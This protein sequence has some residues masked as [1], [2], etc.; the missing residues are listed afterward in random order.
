MHVEHT[1]ILPQMSFN[2]QILD[3]FNTQDIFKRKNGMILR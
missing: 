1:K 2:F 3:D